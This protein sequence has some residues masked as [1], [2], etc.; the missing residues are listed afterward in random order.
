MR[1]SALGS[2]AATAVVLAMGL[3]AYAAVT[4][5]FAALTADGV[6]RAQLERA[7]RALPALALVDEHGRDL[8]LGRY[9]AASP[10]ATFVTLIYVQ[11]QS[12]CRG[13]ISGQS[14]LQHAIESRGLRHRLRLLTLSFDPLNDTPAVM[15]AHARRVDADPDLWRFATVRD[16]ADLPALLKTFG[17]VVL[18]DGMGGYS[19]NAALF[20]LDTHGRLSKA[21]DIDR[22]DLALADYLARGAGGRGG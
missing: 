12:I 8:S 3:A 15:A 17:I 9:G 16:P 4:A 21:Y 13:S 7:P 22:P 11:C 18:P 2:L 5:G 10:Y 20:L 14:W 19:H 6:R 1:S